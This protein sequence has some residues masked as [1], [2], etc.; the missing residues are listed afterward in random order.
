MTTRTSS[1]SDCGDGHGGAMPLF[2]RGTTDTATLLKTLGIEGNAN[3]HIIITAY[4]K[5]AAQNHPDK[6]YAEGPEAQSDAAARFIEITRA[7]EA[8]MAIYRD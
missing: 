6:V 7:Y 5:L 4:R 2:E 3:R 8:L 1:N